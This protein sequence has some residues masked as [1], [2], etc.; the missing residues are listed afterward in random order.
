MFKIY[1]SIEKTIQGIVT[2]HAGNGN[3][4]QEDMITGRLG[5]DLAASLNNQSISYPSFSK[6]LTWQAYRNTGKQKLEQR[7]G[8]MAILLVIQY[9]DGPKL[10]GIAFL[11]AKRI[12]ASHRFDE[13]GIDQLR[14]IHGNAPYAQL[15]LYDY[16]PMP[17][18]FWRVPAISPGSYFHTLP[19]AT[20]IPLVDQGVVDQR[21]YRNCIPLAAQI[22][23]RFF[24]GLDLHYDPKI[25]ADTK[26]ASEEAPAFLNVVQLH[27][28]DQRPVAVTLSEFWQP[29]E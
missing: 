12:Y 26:E 4:W 19:I 9:V 1:E 11:E 27:Y 5:P 2:A 23:M 15:L 21:L 14:R 8:D 25:L 22:T 3:W 16:Q 18:P 20:A 10:E 7:Y 28:P 6:R 13:L 24:F 29:V 17:T